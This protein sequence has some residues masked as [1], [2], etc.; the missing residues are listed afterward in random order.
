MSEIARKHRMDKDGMERPG[1]QGFSLIE[2]LVTFTI[3]MIGLTGLLMLHTSLIKG[4]RS[5]GR[6]V[7]AKGFAKRA[8]EEIRGLTL[9]EIQDTY[10]GGVAIPPLDV[11]LPDVQGRNNLVFERR[12]MISDTNPVDP[13]LMLIRVEVEWTDLGA[14]AG[15][16]NG[17]YDHLVAVELIRARDEI[18]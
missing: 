1:E 3:A 11:A 4:N 15:A 18:L 8:V 9:V 17:I 10:N 2:V 12:L 14:V 13:D 7:E 16:D 5:A 6:A